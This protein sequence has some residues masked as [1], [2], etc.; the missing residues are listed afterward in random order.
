MDLGKKLQN[1]VMAQ[2]EQ[3]FHEMVGSIRHPT[4]GEFPTLVVK[5]DSLDDLRLHG[6]GSPELLEL[7]KQRLGSEAD[8]M[9]FQE[10]QSAARPRVFLSYTTADQVIARKIA[11]ALIAQGVETWWDQWEIR[12]GDS[13]RQKIEEGLGRCTHF[14]VLLSATSIQKPWVNAELDVAFVRKLNDQCRLIPLRYGIEPSDLPTLLQG[15]RSPTISAD[16]SDIQQIINDIYGLTEKPPLG[17]APASA[18]HSSSTGYSAA[19]TAVARMFVEASEHGNSF[20]PMLSVA[21]LCEKTGLTEED[22][23][24]A[25]HELRDFV[26]ERFRIV[27]CE[28]DLFAEFDQHWKDWNPAQDALTLAAAMVNSPQFPAVMSAISEQLGWAARRLN[29]AASYLIRRNLVGSVNALGSRP[30]IAYRITRN[31]ATR[32]FVKSRQGK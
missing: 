13:L 10:T 11:E 20:D 9:T 5:G 26:E 24:D 2:V 28:R 1:Y 14:V 15:L 25:V 8:G 27:C 30:Y 31:D 17:N 32:R 7:V 12:A 21:K 19:A 22:L 16:A 3:H 6:E 29:P 4:T 23:D 18:R